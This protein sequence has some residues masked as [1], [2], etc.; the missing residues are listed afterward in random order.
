MGSRVP[1]HAYR[2]RQDDFAKQ[3]KQKERKIMGLVDLSRPEDV[4]S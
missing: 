4:E 1:E 2:A 3:L